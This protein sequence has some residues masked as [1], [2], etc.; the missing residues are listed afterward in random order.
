[1]FLF[2]LSFG[3]SFL[4]LGNSFPCI[5]KIFLS[6]NS[7][8]H[9]ENLTFSFLVFGNSFFVFGNSFFI[10]GNAYLVFRNSFFV[11]RN[12]YLV[13][14]NFFLVFGNSFLV[15]INSSLLFR[16]FSLYSKTPYIEKL[17]PC[18]LSRCTSAEPPGP[19]LNT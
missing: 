12:S 18:I 10:F 15:F 1:M 16:I 8:L 3:K 5:W 9:S 11:F 14:G 19:G 13:L 4:V 7:T 17:F 2:S 6:G